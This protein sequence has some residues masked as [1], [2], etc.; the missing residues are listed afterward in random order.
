MFR[1]RVPFDNV[2]AEKCCKKVIGERR[3]FT[4]ENV[5]EGRF[6]LVIQN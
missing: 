1:L 5:E 6:Q 4:F 3:V 2:R